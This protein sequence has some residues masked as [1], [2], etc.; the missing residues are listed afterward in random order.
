M[1]RLGGYWTFSHSDG[2]LDLIGSKVLG[3]LAAYPQFAGYSQ[4]LPV[5]ADDSQPAAKI[6][7]ITLITGYVTAFD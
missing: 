7:T 2:L 4:L 3:A 1:R 5:W 6:N